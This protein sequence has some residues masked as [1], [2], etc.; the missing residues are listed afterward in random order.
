MWHEGGLIQSKILPA[1]LCFLFQIFRFF[2]GDILLN[3]D[4]LFHLDIF[5]IVR[6]IKLITEVYR[7]LY[8]CYNPSKHPAIYHLLLDCDDVIFHW[9]Y[10]AY[11]NFER[12]MMHKK[13]HSLKSHEHSTS[14]VLYCIVFIMRSSNP[15]KVDTYGILNLSYTVI[16]QR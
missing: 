1:K 2:H 4:I 15:Y 5:C 16:I 9:I 13:H 10:E 12:F 7:L 14:F 11:G 6:Y 3:C 8:T